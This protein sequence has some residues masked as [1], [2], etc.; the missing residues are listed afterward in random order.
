MTAG[1]RS[2]KLLILSPD[3]GGVSEEIQAKLL[4]RFADYTVMKFN[5]RR[6]IRKE[7]TLRATV[8]VAG[9]DGTVGCVLRQLAGGQARIGLLPLGTYN[10]FARGLDVP[11]DLDKAIRVISRGKVRRVT[12]GRINEKPFLET[13]AIGMFGE[14]IVLGE[15][16]KALAFGDIAPHLKAAIAAERFEYA[17]EGDLNGNG[18]TRSLVFT[19]TP[20]T[21][22]LMGVGGKKPRQ[23]YLELAVR[24]GQSRSDVIG[25]IVASAVLNKHEAEEEM[26]FGFTS[27]TVTTKP[28][29]VI[30][31]D[32]ERAGRTPARIEAIPGAIRVFVP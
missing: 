6:D 7:I 25:R 2:A 31:A 5:P 14:T 30:Y 18:A 26:S 3:A 28:K 19:N 22:A 29:M 21:G 1:R 4:A 15:G 13:A 8:V 17:L 27:L 12:L 24:V 16:I 20:S 9:G 11:E 23:P 32:N 10:N